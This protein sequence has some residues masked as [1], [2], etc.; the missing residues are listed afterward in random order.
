MS[1]NNPTKFDRR[2]II[3]SGFLLSLGTFLISKSQSI[4]GNSLNNSLNN[5]ISDDN[6]QMGATSLIYPFTLPKL[7]YGFAALEP[8]IDKMTMEI[9]YT[10]HHQGYLN[11]LNKIIES[12]VSLQNLKIEEVLPKITNEKSDNG[13]KNNAGGHFNHT[14]FWNILTPKQSSKEPK[15]DFLNHVIKD[16]GSLDRLKVSFD[17]AAKTRFGSGWAW[18]VYDDN[19]RKLKVTSTPNQDNPLMNFSEVKGKPIMGID[20]WEHA[21]Y[22]KYQNKRADYITSFWNILDWSKVEN[23]YNK[24]TLK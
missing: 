12:N 5:N 14:F 19:D 17:E 24:A 23:N 20:V 8:N 18:L 13:L 9:H 1:V 10:K 11:N 2:N 21:Y 15:G 16:F 3:K 22:L 4:A 6:S 7:E